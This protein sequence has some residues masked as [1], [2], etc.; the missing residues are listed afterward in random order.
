VRRFERH[1]A[2]TILH[3]NATQWTARFVERRKREPGARF[4]WPI[5]D[6]MPVNR[7]LVRPLGAMTD[8]HCAYCDGFPLDV[9]SVETID[10]FRPK[11]QFPA[12]AFQWE[13]LY[14]CC[15]GCQR[16][17]GSDFDDAWL[18]PDAVDYRFE[19][20]FVVN[21][22]TGEIE[23]HPGASARDQERARATIEDFGLN[24]PARVSDRLRQRRRWAQRLQAGSTD[25]TAELPY[26]FFLG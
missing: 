15:E 10:H 4:A 22:R 7:Q 3:D 24:K 12:L 5:V 14:L 11:S 21:F 1:P 26:R 2:P 25:V 8:D 23:V 9:V 16:E 13:N 19:R 6:G 20:Y 17:K 18:R